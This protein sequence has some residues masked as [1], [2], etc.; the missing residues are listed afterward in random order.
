MENMLEQKSAKARL[1]QSPRP[2]TPR[3]TG[4][5]LGERVLAD[6]ASPAR[7]QPNANGMT[8]VL[9]IVTVVLHSGSA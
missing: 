3:P 2:L 9:V 6:I 5:L 1:P 8:Q 7:D 4:L